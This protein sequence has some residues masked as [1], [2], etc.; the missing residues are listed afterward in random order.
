MRCGGEMVSRAVRHS[1]DDL[2]EWSIYRQNL[3]SS[4]ANALIFRKV[5]ALPYGDFHM[6]EEA[7]EGVIRAGRMEDNQLSQKADTYLKFGLP[8][9]AIHEQ[10]GD[11]TLQRPIAFRRSERMFEER[12]TRSEWD[13]PGHHKSGGTNGTID[14]E[15]A[16]LRD[17]QTSM[18][19]S[20]VAH[21]AESDIFPSLGGNRPNS[22]FQSDRHHAH[23]FSQIDLFQQ[24]SGFNYL[25]YAKAE[26]LRH[27]DISNKPYV[28]ISNLTFATDHRSAFDR[29][30]LRSAN[31]ERTLNDI[32]FQLSGGEVVALLYTTESEMRTLLH[33]LAQKNIPNGKLEGTF[34]ING[35]QLTTI[36]FGERVALIDADELFTLLTVKE[37]LQVSSAIVKPATDAFKIDCMIDQ[38]IQ[39]LALS[40][41]R[42]LLCEDLGKTEKQR[43]KIAEQ[44]LKDADILLCDNITKD[45]DLYDTAFVIDYLRDWAVKLN[46]IVVMAVSPPSIEIL[47]MFHKTL[48]LASGQIVYC[49]RSSEMIGYFESVNFPCPMFKNPC[50]YYVDLVTHDHLTPDASTESTQRIKHLAD[51]W[52]H[53]ARTAE[54]L[55]V[56]GPL[57]PELRYANCFVVAL[58][59]FALV[60]SIIMGTIFFEIPA[61]RRASIND[62]FGFI[63]SILTI[64]L[65]PNLLINIDKVC[66]DR[67][68]LHND[69]RSRYYG[70]ACYLLV[71]IIFDLPIAISSYIV[72]AV[73]AYL[74]TDLPSNTRFWPSLFAFMI[75]VSLYSILW[76]YISWILAFVFSSRMMAAL[77]AVAL[78]CCCAFGSGL[79]VH[80]DDLLPA[81]SHIQMTNPTRW[82]AQIMAENEFLRKAPLIEKVAELISAG[83][84][85]NTTELIIGCERKKILATKIK[86]VKVYPVPIYTVLQCSKIRGSQAL[87]FSGF[88]VD[89]V[90]P[91]VRFVSLVQHFCIYY[92]IVFIVLLL[93]VR[94]NHKPISVNDV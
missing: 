36:Q 30:M 26:E 18:L 46:R 63:F 7:I 34:E 12:K 78:M 65:L 19:S 84:E 64:F 58:I 79:L 94:I 29:A 42:N 44:I 59:L 61:D 86:E 20:P 27:D 60:T 56:T 22:F 21:Y 40:P 3:T 43:L 52:R 49:G 76:R 17:G 16:T 69:L 39:T 48:L 62:R 31:F 6:N 1:K 87:Y 75:I 2:H 80:C 5:R 82:A 50:D 33:V 8:R 45:M 28:R 35:N 66:K 32:S 54:Q 73:P 72:Y 70:P 47:T 9:V 81:A 71:K 37:T 10:S 23:Y 13:L 77:G 88:R 67:L 14:Q 83:H 68:F 93:T 51:L 85:R 91:N 90:D 24:P 55:T 92:A 41:Y 53:N 25:R 11:Y 15:C 57:S 4:I 74:L 38:M 89:N